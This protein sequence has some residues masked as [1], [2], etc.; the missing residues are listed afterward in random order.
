MA[1]EHR[2]SS[3]TDFH[4]HGYFEQVVEMEPSNESELR[5]ILDVIEG[6][7]VSL[8][9]LYS[10]FVVYKVSEDP[11][12]VELVLRDHTD[13][14][15]VVRQRI[16]EIYRE[17][18][19]LA[20]APVVGDVS[21]SAPVIGENVLVS[22]Q[23]EHGQDLIPAKVLDAI[24]S[25]GKRTKYLV[26]MP[27]GQEFPL[28]RTNLYT[29][30]EASIPHSH[31]PK[32]DV[33]PETKELDLPSAESLHA[34]GIEPDDFAKH[35]QF[36]VKHAFRKSVFCTDWAHCTVRTEMIPMTNEDIEAFISQD[37]DHLQESVAPK[38]ASVILAEADIRAHR[39]GGC[40][41]LD[42]FGLPEREVGCGWG[43]GIRDGETEREGQ[44]ERQI[45]C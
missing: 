17:V 22:M 16:E 12:D 41:S 34:R 3:P 37:W 43:W 35:M 20:S 11:E 24:A 4:L 45:V 6:D 15:H 8:D 38:I 31:I 19:K 14:S 10:A 13:G 26:Q 2:A 1:G 42:D 27:D 40:F 44:T 9:D 32:P 7:E 30:K 23:G 33:L 28:N 21:G 25:E 36:A 29:M 39:G 18:K 5:Q